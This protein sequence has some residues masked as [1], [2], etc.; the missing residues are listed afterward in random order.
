MNENTVKT[1]LV[2]ARMQLKQEYTS[3]EDN[4]QKKR[5]QQKK[6]KNREFTGI[7]EYQ[8]ENLR[9]GSVTAGNITVSSRKE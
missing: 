1:R 9:T 3:A 7:A 2:R 5:L 6:K 8:N 4:I